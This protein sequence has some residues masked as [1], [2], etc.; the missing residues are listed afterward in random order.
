MSEND[1]SDNSPE[2][3]SQGESSIMKID[4]S[5]FIEDQKA[6][7]LQANK[8]EARTWFEK[9]ILQSIDNRLAEADSYPDI[10]LWTRVRGEVLKQ[11]ESATEQSHRRSL[12]KIQ[13]LYK[14]TF[15]IGAFT[16]GTVLIVSSF[17][18]P[19]FFI[20][21]AGLYGLAP[22]YVL[23]FFKNFYRNENS[24]ERQK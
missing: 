2:S 17:V 5:R 22:S 3:P 7:D 18:Y 6:T 11:N 4:E 1:S 9:D 10:V 8:N 13:L 19:G 12:E 14:M 21:G 15:S 23:D 16:V 24:K 20:L